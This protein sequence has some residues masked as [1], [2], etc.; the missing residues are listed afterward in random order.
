[1][2]LAKSGQ[3]PAKASITTHALASPVNHRAE[4]QQASPPCTCAKSGERTHTAAVTLAPLLLAIFPYPGAIPPRSRWL[5]RRLSCFY[6]GRNAKTPPAAGLR[7]VMPLAKKAG[8][9]P[10]TPSP[11]VQPS[12]IPPPSCRLQGKRASVPPASLKIVCASLQ[13]PLRFQPWRRAQQQHIPGGR[14]KS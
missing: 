2:S 6:A 9:Q 7:G 14:C 11:I 13:S 4:K 3:A 10:A 1:M 8:K 5:F 12:A